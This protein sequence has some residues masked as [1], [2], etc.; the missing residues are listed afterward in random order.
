MRLLFRLAVEFVPPSVTGT[1]LASVMFGVAPP[2]E[3]SG[4]LAVTFVTADTTFCHV[5]AV[6]L[7]AVRTWP[8]V[9]AVAADTSTVVV[10]ENN[11]FAVTL[12][13]VAVIVLLVNV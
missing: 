8:A 7:V 5:A 6:A 9:G 11:P 12:L 4:E 10:A 3:A 13:V 2:V 1:A